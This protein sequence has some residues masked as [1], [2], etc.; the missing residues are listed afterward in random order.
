MTFPDLDKEITPE[1]GDECV[2]ASGMLPL[3]GQ[4]MCGTAQTHKQDSNGDPIG[5]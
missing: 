1:A 4:M 5:R 3:G 2:H